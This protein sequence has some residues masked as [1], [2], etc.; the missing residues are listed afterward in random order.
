MKERGT[1]KTRR[2]EPAIPRMTPQTPNHDPT[3]I[4]ILLHSLKQ[5]LHLTHI[6]QSSL[7]REKRLAILS[8]Q[9]RISSHASAKRPILRIVAHALVPHNRVRP[10]PAVV[11][12]REN[13]NV[14]GG[15]GVGGDAV[16][17]IA[18]VH[19]E[20]VAVDGFDVFG[21]FYCP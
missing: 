4:R 21:D 2:T 14:R 18:A 19:D 13:V 9:G 11:M 12:V 5:L 16:E 15:E 1:T 3:H 17:H 6:R 8:S 20:V 10:T 7:P